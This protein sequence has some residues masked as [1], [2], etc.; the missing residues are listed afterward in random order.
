MSIR[1]VL[2]PNSTNENINILKKTGFEHID[3]ISRY[4]NFEGYLAIK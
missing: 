2:K 1:G 3:I 4:C